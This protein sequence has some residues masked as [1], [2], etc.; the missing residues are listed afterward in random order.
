[1]PT[2]PTIPENGPINRPLLNTIS[3][4][5]LALAF[6]GVLAKTV[7]SLGA[8][9]P[10][11]GETI[12]RQALPEA[13]RFVRLQ[14]PFPHYMA[15]DGQGGSM[16]AV[17]LTD[18]C[19]PSIKGY[20]GVIHMAVGVSAKGVIAGVV[21]YSHNE[22]PYYMRMISNAGLTNTFSGI[23]LVETF[24]QPDAVSGAT[25]S[26]MA[27]IRDARSSAILVAQSLFGIRTARP[28]AGDGR[29]PL[30]W[31]TILLAGALGLSL[32]AARSGSARQLREV[33]IALN[34][35][36]V[37]ILV[38]SPLTLSVASRLMTLNFP[39]WGNTYLLLILLYLALSIPLSGRSYCRYVCPFGA[40][41]HLLNRWWPWK[42]R[43]GTAMVSF[44]PSFRKLLLALLLT[45]TVPMSMTGFSQIEPFYSLFSFRMTPLVWISVTV[46][47][48]I[49][50]FWRRFW[51]NAFCPTG[52]L[53]ALLCRLL[54]P[55]RG[56]I[57][58]SV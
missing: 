15:F 43:P 25:V 28:E 40:L 21:P 3:S 31:R 34:L 44:L 54:R 27:I 5:L 50:L 32:A 29:R 52:T 35:L 53:V 24:P 58:E 55:G 7:L 1:M 16:G 39:G 41:Q 12:L 51:C 4:A 26:S 33:S 38:N 45:L 46:I 13:H 11:P 8:D 22:T 56:N 30:P 23:D 6:L 19:P 47:I 9:P 49:C 14:D 37:G 57:D 36:V 42:Y 20:L 17:V 18:D 10:V 2:D 48:I